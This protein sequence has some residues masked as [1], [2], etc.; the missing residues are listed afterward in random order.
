MRKMI[1]TEVSN[2]FTVEFD[3]NIEVFGLPPKETIFVEKD[4][5]GL[6]KRIN[7]IFGDPKIKLIV[8]S[9]DSDD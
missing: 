4:F 3:K 8:D 1:I 9:G 7:S 2:G 6:F 5:K